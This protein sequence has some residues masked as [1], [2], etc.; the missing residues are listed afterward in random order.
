MLGISRSPFPVEREGVN[1]F[2]RLGIFDCPGL[3]YFLVFR[4]HFGA[5]LSGF[6]LSEIVSN[7]KTDLFQCLF[8]DSWNFFQ[9]LGRHVGQCFDR[10]DAG[11]YQLLNDLF[12]QFGHL[13]NWGRRATT[14][15]LHLLFDFLALLFL[16]LD[17]DLPTQQFGGQAHVLALF[18]D[19]QGKLGIV[20]DHFDLLF[21]EVRNTYS[22]YLGRLEGFFG[23]RGDF[24]AVLD[25]VDFLAAQLAND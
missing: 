10:G 24:F 23:E 3:F 12:A 16:A 7:C 17:V 11:N 8:P 25:D 19:G 14:H 5:F 2:F 22:A 4:F 1:F 6:V 21:S 9:L 18:A 15:C 13:L 20:D